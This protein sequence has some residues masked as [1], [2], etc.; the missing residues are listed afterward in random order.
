MLPAPLGP[1]EEALNTLEGDHDLP[2]FNMG[3]CA[4]CL[5]QV[6]DYH[7]LLLKSLICPSHSFSKGARSSAVP[8]LTKS[9]RHGTLF[10]N[11]V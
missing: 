3:C 11:H 4:S 7:S 6:N 5:H 9:C 1:A 2:Q 8:H 10:S